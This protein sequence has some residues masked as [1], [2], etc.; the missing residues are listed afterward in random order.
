M[1]SIRGRQTLLS[2]R[3]NVIT[4]AVGALAVFVFFVNPL[5]YPR[6]IAALN[7][8]V[9]AYGDLTDRTISSIEDQTPKG[10]LYV[11]SVQ[12]DRR[13]HRNRPLQLNGDMSRHQIAYNG[14]THRWR[15]FGPFSGKNGIDPIPYHVDSTGAIDEAT[16][17]N[18]ESNTRDG[19]LYVRVVTTDDRVNTSYP[20]NGSML[21]HQISYNGTTHKWTDHGQFTGLDGDP[22]HVDNFGPLTD[23]IVHSIEVVLQP[24]PNHTAEHRGERDNVYIYVVTTDT[25]VNTSY[26]YGLAPDLSRHA[27]AY[28]GHDWVDYGPFTGATGIPGAQGPQGEQGPPGTTN[29]TLDSECLA[30]TNCTL[31]KC[32]NG[33]CRY[34]LPTNGCSYNRDCLS[35]QVCSNCTCVVACDSATCAATAVNCEVK[36][37]VDGSCVL[38]GEVTGCCQNT[39]DCTG[40][41]NI[42]YFV[43]NLAVDTITR[44]TGTSDIVVSDPMSFSPGDGIGIGMAS[45]PNIPL[46]IHGNGASSNSEILNLYDLNGVAK[47]HMNIHTSTNDGLNFA[48]TSV[49]DARLYLKPGGNVGINTAD[50]QYNLHVVG[51]GYIS[52]SLLVGQN[53]TVSGWTTLNGLNN[54]GLSTLGTVNAGTCSLGATTVNSLTVTNS[55]TVGQNLTVS[56]W[57]TLNGLT[58]AGQST[59]GPLSAGTSSLGATTVNSLTV[60]NSE[61]VGQNLTVSGWTTLNGLNNAGLSTLGTVN[62]GATTVNSLTVTNSATVGQ[63]LTV[64]GWTILN[65]LN[66]NG[67]STLGT[68]NAGTCSLGATTVNSLTVT[69]SETVGQNLT[70]NGWTTLNGLNNAGLSTLDTVNAGTCSL[71]AT[72]VNSLTVTNSATV[73]QNLTVNGWTTLNGLNNNGLSNLGTVN[74]G[75]TTLTGALSGTSASFSTTLGV[76]GA[77]TLT[78]SLSGSSATFSTTL[79]V[80]GLLTSTTGVRLGTGPTTLNYYETGS[81]QAIFSCGNGGSGSIFTM[82]YSRIGNLVTVVFPSITVTTSTAPTNFITS[83]T[84]NIPSQIR[85]ATDVSS[86][87]RGILSGVTYRPFSLVA[88]ADGFIRIY[89]HVNADNLDFA[90]YPVNSPL[91]GLQCLNACVLSWIYNV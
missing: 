25:R 8:H 5:I 72:T 31:N 63:N 13:A 86:L 37:C 82:F 35:N 45:V 22:F 28:D 59:L 17:A 50:P 26:P 53:L 34:D 91:A 18:I 67:L 89:N 68:V 6:I 60:T 46:V 55:A 38:V 1:L 79:G 69:N 83:G 3:V 90:N 81:F 15:D 87:F 4:C 10:Y 24:S 20:L 40:A 56:G 78:G 74:A 30:G 58:N 80:T 76:T 73:G 70:V 52:S 7:Y 85:P 43:N 51:N 64:S 19:Y 77:T 84:S 41:S 65:G 71:G 57:T 61:T 16:L 23:N 2:F 49:S 14:T 48:E 39:L 21:R 33:T 47:W 36:G 12:D 66:N 88:R 27:I 9:D 54:A 44:K 32:L 75:A 42:N 62:A 29:C 11:Y